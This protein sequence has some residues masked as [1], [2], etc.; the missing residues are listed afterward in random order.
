MNRGGLLAVLALAVASVI[1]AS[2]CTGAAGGG[3]KAGGGT[4]PLDLTMASR[5]GVIDW[6]PGV[7]DFVGRVG[8]LSGGALRIKVASLWAGNG[9][10]DAE[11]RIVRDVAAGKADL[12]WVGTRVFDTLGVK[13]FQALTAPMLIDS[14]PL[15]RAVIG[16][17][18]PG[19]MLQSLDDLGV[20]GLA[21]LADGLHKPIAAR[22]PLLGQADWN[23]ITFATI[24]SNGE[25]EAIQALGARSTDLWGDPLLQA[26]DDGTIQ[27]RELGLYSYV[28]TNL[29]QVP[30]VTANVN[31]WPETLVL[32]ANP[33]L[34]STLTDQQ[35]EWLQRAAQEAAGGSTGLV[36]NDADNVKLACQN[37]GR[38][39]NASDADLAWLRQS[40]A[41]VYADLE[42][43]PET[44]NY[45]AAIEQ[46]KGTMPLDPP[47]DIPPGC[48]G[49]PPKGS[50][51][52]VVAGTWQTAQLTE[53]EIVQAFVAA[54]GSEKDGHE[55]FSGMREGSTTYAVITLQFQA[56][57]FKQF[58]SG[59][60]GKLLEGSRGTYQIA[61]DDTIT[62]TGCQD[63]QL[64]RFD[65]NGDT[66]RFYVVTPC[67]TENAPYETTLF[68][69][70]PMTRTG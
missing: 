54:G 30:Y 29:E 10:P 53:S 2:A 46:L 58:Q 44:K 8:Q 43:D 1:L 38:V 37:G 22:G 60:D 3:N 56:G 16:S 52:D 34:L 26:F 18:I 62:M 23:G 33:H 11:Q 40:F 35:R 70:F 5:P 67:S 49:P 4:G 19:R 51:D 64:Y 32:L 7:A 9:E 41:P 59:G 50:A 14:Y 61:G 36:D 31:L 69:S 55:L 28:A 25:S 57:L 21:V 17:D 45:I 65:L 68:A 42:Q 15:E 39:A 6:V 13:S 47:L 12:G 27:G 20:A 24:R 66:L 63:F 48:S